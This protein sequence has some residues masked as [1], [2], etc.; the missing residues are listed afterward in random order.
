MLR[1]EQDEAG[2]PRWMVNRKR[3]YRVYR[4]EGLAM[5]RRKRK[6]FRA[7]VRVPLEAPR[8]PN[9]GRSMDFIHDTLST[10]GNFAC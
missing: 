6:R 2:Q 3:V 8:C 1:R 9:E 4:E 5:R 7:E 10:G